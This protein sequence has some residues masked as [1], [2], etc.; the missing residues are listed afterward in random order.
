MQQAKE[1]K[2]KWVVAAS[3]LNNTGASFLWPLTTVYMHNY[4]H[5][6]LATAGVVLF[7]MSCAMI[8]GNYLGGWLFDRWSPYKTALTSVSIATIAV[9][10]LI[11]FHSWPIFAVLL[12]FVGFGDGAN[13]TVI[14]AYAAS[15]KGH[16]VRY[17]FNVLYM[18]LNLGVVV[19]TLLVGFLMSLGV[20]VV[21]TVTSICYA[22][23][24][25]L[26][27]TTFNVAVPK[28]NRKLENITDESKPF[29]RTSSLVWLICM[30]VISTYLSYTLWESVMAVH[31]TNMHIPF[32]AYSLLWTM[33][34]IIILLG[35]PL[36]NK[37]E[38]YLKIDRQIEIGITIFA[39]SFFLLI[40][41]NSFVWFIVD[42]VIL[43]IGEMMG[44]PSIPA[45]IDQLTNPAQTGKYQGMMN[46]SISIGRAIGPLYGGM[47]IDGFG[48]QS[49]FLSV[50]VI[51]GICLLLVM[52]NVRHV[53]KNEG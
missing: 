39:F 26:T 1:I 8:L 38:P 23:F 36:V 10:A 2:L 3:F 49:L 13:I 41:A 25:I 4:L 11:F 22:S 14:N 29:A 28:R 7:F 27:I 52:Q 18:A 16:K 6:S 47:I 37:L 15:I 19:G 31:L 12:L 30:L 43:T 50:T 48:Y 24:L 5:E 9:V 33:N 35:Q 46:M 51:M 40:F 17:I 42:F 32:Y 34:G 21:F 20:T 45:W 53:R 44:L